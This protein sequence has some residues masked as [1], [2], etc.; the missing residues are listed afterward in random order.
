MPA[1]VAATGQRR[2]WDRFGEEIPC[3]GTGQDGELRPGRPWPDPRFSADGGLVRD[4]LSGLTWLRDAGH[5]EWPASWHEASAAIAAL[6]RTRHRGRGDWRLPDRRELWSLICFGARDPALPA[7]NPFRNVVLG[8]YWSSTSSARNADY[9]WAVQTTGGR[10]F[11]E[12][13]ER[14]AFVWP[15]AGTGRVLAAT[16]QPV[17]RAPSGGAESSA[18]HRQV[19]AVHGVVWPTPRFRA[20]GDGVRDLLTGLCW[21]ERADLSRGAVDWVDALAAVDRINRER[22]HTPRWR[23]PTIVELESL[24]DARQCDP[25]LPGGHP[26]RDV[27]PGYWSSTTSAYEPDWAMVLHMGR[28]A[29]GVGI[30]RDPRYR[31]WPVRCP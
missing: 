9:A 14:D 21:M 10:V 5:F 17:D 20:E 1:R 27:G 29:I 22:P 15:C 23:L 31:V 13:K 6:N 12:H 19:P 4:H 8:W 25:S 24:L 30:K 3:S 18:E 7:G 26:F 2:C 28:G 16:G 11:F